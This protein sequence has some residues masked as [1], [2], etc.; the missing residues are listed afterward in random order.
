M[1]NE[2]S[3]SAESAELILFAQLDID[4]I[5]T[6]VSSTTTM[7]ALHSGAA[8]NPL[9][10]ARRALFESVTDLLAAVDANAADGRPVRAF[11]NDAGFDADAVIAAIEEEHRFDEAA[12]LACAATRSDAEERLVQRASVPRPTDESCLLSTNALRMLRTQL[13]LAL[14]RRSVDGQAAL[15][16]ARALNAARQRRYRAERR[17]ARRLAR[18]ALD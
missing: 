12:R 2:L 6:R 9:A 7:C 15:Q 16:R 18:P 11:I 14:G 10:H 1:L 4:S 13:L 8:V 17:E 5:G 3:E